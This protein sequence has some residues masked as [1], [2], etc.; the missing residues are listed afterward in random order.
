MRINKQTTRL[1]DKKKV[2][3]PETKKVGRQKSHFCRKSKESFARVDHKTNVRALI[4]V[5]I[6]WKILQ[7]QNQPPLLPAF[8]HGQKHRLQHQPFESCSHHLL[9]RQ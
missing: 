4:E 6:T 1:I 3:L 8:L 9:H 2:N 7:L 5:S